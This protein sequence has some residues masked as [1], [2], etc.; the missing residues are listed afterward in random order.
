MRNLIFLIVFGLVLNS[1]TFH[2]PE[3]K[4]KETVKFESI[5]GKTIKFTAGATFYN[6]NGYALKVKPSKL[7]LYIEDEYIGKV[8]LENKVKLRRKRETSVES[9][10]TVV[11]ENGVMM[12]LIKYATQG[13]VKI[14]LKGKV[15][16]GVFIFSK[17]FDVNETKTIDGSNLKLGF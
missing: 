5:E 4:G 7:D 16:G 14:R 6:E 13:K 1:C 15:K 10:F 2:E 17:K 3:Y 8:K 11:L 12:K 9:P